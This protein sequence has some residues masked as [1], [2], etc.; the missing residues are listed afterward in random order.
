MWSCWCCAM[1]WRCCAVPTRGRGWT[2]RTGPVL[3]ALIRAMPVWLRRHRLVTP[4]TV[5][6]W[7][8]RLVA[9]RWTFPHRVGRPPVDP[10]VAALVARLASENPGW[11]YQRIQG[12]LVKVGHR[13]S[14]ATIRRVL[15]GL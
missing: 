11:G 9:R 8:R 15:M 7:H 2:G 14:A 1:R 5:L 4:G 3:P 6:R 13:V 10:V 12:E